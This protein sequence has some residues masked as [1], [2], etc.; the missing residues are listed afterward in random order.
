MFICVYLI[1]NLYIFQR[2]VPPI[3]L[4]TNQND[5]WKDSSSDDDITNA[6]SLKSEPIDVD[7]FIQN[8][9]PSSTNVRHKS[10]PKC[11]KQKKSE[12]KV[13]VSIGMLS[14]KTKIMSVKDKTCLGKAQVCPVFFK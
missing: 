9:T 8:N 5:S 14:K 3:P 12:P 10:A 6:T 2:R 13:M 4:D 1:L 11:K 7:L